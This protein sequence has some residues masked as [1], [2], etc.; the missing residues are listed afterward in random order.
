MSKAKSKA[1]TTM[2]EPKPVPSAQDADLIRL[3]VK[4]VQAIA[5]ARAGYEGDPDGNSIYATAASAPYYR[6]IEKLMAEI[7]NTPAKTV[8]GVCAKARAM[9]AFVEDTSDDLDPKWGAFIGSLAKDT[10]EYATEVQDAQRHFEGALNSPTDAPSGANEIR[11]LNVWAKTCEKMHD[12]DRKAALALKVAGAALQL[13][14][15]W[16]RLGMTA[17]DGRKQDEILPAR[18]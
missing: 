11:A 14:D 2:P 12:P 7:S 13:T 15:K 10:R 5:A 9:Q 3:C 18:R 16:M 8:Y 1:I 4:Y 6:Q 17:D